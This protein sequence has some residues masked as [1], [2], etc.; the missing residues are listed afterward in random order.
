MIRI[1]V[2][3]VHRMKLVAFWT[4]RYWTMH[5]RRSARSLPSAGGKYWGASTDNWS[6]GK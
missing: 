4:L 3:T 6:S 5:C 2:A 1:G